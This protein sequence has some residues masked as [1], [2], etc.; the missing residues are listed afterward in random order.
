MIRSKG[1]VGIIVLIGLFGLGAPA[2]FA[3]ASLIDVEFSDG[4]PPVK[5]GYAA[6]GRSDKDLWNVYWGVTAPHVPRSSGVLT[7]LKYV[8][9]APSGAA[10]AIT[11][12]GSA[13]NNGA[14]DDMYQGYLYPS[15]GGNI[16]LTV[17]NL[18]AGGYDF[19]FYGHGDHD[20]QNSIFEL[21]VDGAS[22]GERATLNGPGWKSPVW[23]EGV[24][25]VRFPNVC[26]AAGQT[27]NI[28][29]KLGGSRYAC[30]VGMQIA[31]SC[32]DQKIASPG[33]DQK[34]P[35]S[36]DDPAP[37]PDGACRSGE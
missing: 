5:V 26:V 24:Q 14:D 18:K 33:D 32:E 17:T 12:A 4:G 13:C 27:I 21:K 30:F 1:S 22:Q 19:Y 35:P 11:N 15:G 6:T 8:D 7:D 16:S 23:Q 34:I 3:A 10:V 25:Y 37:D 31:S 29:V 36:C 2:V 20:N 28:E 9:G